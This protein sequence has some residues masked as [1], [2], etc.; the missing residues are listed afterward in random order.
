MSVFRESVRLENYAQVNVAGRIIGSIQNHLTYCK[1]KFSVRDANGVS[2]FKIKGSFCFPLCFWS[3]ID[4]F[5]SY[6]IVNVHRTSI[7]IFFVQ[8]RR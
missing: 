8:F 4:F 1:P 3:E 2:L 5:V 6:K 7:Y